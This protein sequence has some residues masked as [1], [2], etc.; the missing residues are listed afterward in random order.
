MGTARPLDLFG[1]LFGAA[2]AVVV[3]QDL[4]DAVHLGER[5]V[6]GMQGQLHT[7]FGGH[8]QDSLHEVGVVRPDFL[9]R[10]LSLEALFFYFVSEI[11]QPEFAG[12]IAARSFHAIGRVGVGGMK[13][14]AGNRNSQLAKTAQESVVSV[15]LLVAS[16]PAEL[17]VQ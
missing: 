8:R 4:G 3:N 14:V 16:G 13:V 1:N 11:G 6:V 5:R 7:G 17:N 9:R 10:I 12:H 2:I 15:D